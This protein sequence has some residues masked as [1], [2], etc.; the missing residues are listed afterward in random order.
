[1]TGPPPLEISDYVEMVAWLGLTIFLR[2]RFVKERA[3]MLRRSRL[4]GEFVTIT[5]IVAGVAMFIAAA[6]GHVERRP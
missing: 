1:M 5:L 2:W 3:G 6:T 4:L